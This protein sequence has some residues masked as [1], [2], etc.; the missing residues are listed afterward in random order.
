[1]PLQIFRTPRGDSSDPCTLQTLCPPPSQWVSICPRS[2]AWQGSTLET[3][4]LAR[5]SWFP[6]M[7]T[8]NF[9]RKGIE[10]TDGLAHTRNHAAWVGTSS[11]CSQTNAPCD[12]RVGHHANSVERRCTSTAMQG[13]KEHPRSSPGFL[14]TPEKVCGRGGHEPVW[15]PPPIHPPSQ[16]LPRVLYDSRSVRKVG[17][18]H[19]RRYDQTTICR[20]R[21]NRH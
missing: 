7:T 3:A 5:S 15:M 17:A 20:E 4:E 11:E 14:P 9:P 8:H 21:S 2:R 16:P 1:M 13:E 19:E 10:D 6:E 12:R 18:L